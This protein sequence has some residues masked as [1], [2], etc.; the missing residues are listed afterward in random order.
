MKNKLTLK[1]E[2]F[3]QEYAISG[4]KAQSI[5][6]AGYKIGS[7][8]GKESNKLSIASQIGA[9]RLKKV[10]VQQSLEKI[11]AD[12]GI[13]KEAMVGVMRDL[14]F[15]EDKRVQLGVLDML[16]KIEGNYDKKDSKVLGFFSNLES[17]RK[18][19]ETIETEGEGQG[20]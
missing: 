4:N 15:S 14:L 1:E 12:E 19:P 20:E 18:S 16:H 13:T 3:V 7:Q 2:K 17:L 6:K 11:L 5:I 8:G 9:T 10:E